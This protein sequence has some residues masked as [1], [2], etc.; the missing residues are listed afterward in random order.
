MSPTANEKQR[1]ELRGAVTRQL[2]K[3]AELDKAKQDLAEFYQRHPEFE[4]VE[5]LRKAIADI[6]SALR[7]I[8]KEIGRIENPPGACS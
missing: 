2:S 3:Q 5:Q 4:E 8:E 6:E 1:A 7:G